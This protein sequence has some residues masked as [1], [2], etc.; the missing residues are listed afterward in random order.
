MPRQ[1]RQPGEYLHVITRGI[2]KQILFEDANDFE[3]MRFF[4]Q[5]YRDETGITINLL[6]FTRTV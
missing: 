1:A 3:K 2:G 4:L 6:T 5:K